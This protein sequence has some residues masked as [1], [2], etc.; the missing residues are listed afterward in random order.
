MERFILLGLAHPRAAWF[1]TMGQ[2]A[3]AGIIAAD[4]EKC[5]S[6]E[7]LRARLGTGRRYSAALLDGGL[8]ATDR[9]LIAAVRDAGAVAVVVDDG[10]A[11]RDWH[12][13]GASVVLPA[14][15]ERDQLMEALGEHARAV[16]SAAAAPEVSD[17][18]DTSDEATTTTLAPVVAVVGPGGTGASS[19]AIATAQG[20]AADERFASQVVLADL[21]VRADL[22][23]LLDAKDVV[24][25][26]QELVDAARSHR[27]G[28]RQVLPCTHAYRPGGYHVLLGLRRAS[29][30]T[31]IR[32]KAF[33]AAFEALRRS[34]RVVVADCSNDLEGEGTTGSI[35]IE[36]RNVMSRTAV[37]QASVVFAV[38]SPGL[39]GLHGVVRLLSELRELGVPDERVICVINGAPKRPKLRADL[40]RD[41]GALVEA[42][43]GKGVAPLFL[44]PR[45][46]EE[47]L[48]D[49]VP[50]PEP[51]PATLAGAVTAVLQRSSVASPLPPAG[52]EP[53]PISP[54][55]LGLAAEQPAG[56]SPWSPDER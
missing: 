28:P 4:F 48:R 27:L 56:A 11:T 40:T 34:F 2:L 50:L 42:R 9:D 51:L 7:E 14:D 53:A 39:K 16:G 1:R 46:V 17:D 6:A 35:D 43:A 3:T 32:P 24:P 10:R 55:S 20:L 18:P 45:P 19:V 23:M 5:I 29:Q 15:F 25:G 49:G 22:A 12:D 47:A 33:A 36:E 38:G 41:L 8:P 26:V 21:D 44:P 37:E 54:G 31:S 13:V 52:G 30:W